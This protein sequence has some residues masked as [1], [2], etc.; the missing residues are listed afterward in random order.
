MILRTKFT[1]GVET[2]TDI[3]REYQRVESQISPDK[4]LE[5]ER[6][7]YGDNLGTFEGKAHAFIIHDNGKEI[8]PLYKGFD[9]YVL[10]ND[11]TLFND[12]TF[13]E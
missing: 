10:A 4:F 3:G 12:L 7:H 1:D 2:I 8:I 11:G 9:Y 13:K 5:T 6:I